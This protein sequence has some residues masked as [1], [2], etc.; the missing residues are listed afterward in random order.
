MDT[1]NDIISTE[2]IDEDIE[3]SLNNTPGKKVSAQVDTYNERMNTSFP[4]YDDTPIQDIRGMSN[5]RQDSDDSS[6]DLNQHDLL[7]IQNRLF[8]QAAS[9]NQQDNQRQSNTRE[10]QN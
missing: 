3:Y 6:D 7:S 2:D 4:D 1:N 9:G 10:D 5:Q 8:Y